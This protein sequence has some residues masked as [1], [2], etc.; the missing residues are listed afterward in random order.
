MGAMSVLVTHVRGR[1]GELET[2]ARRRRE[3]LSSAL[4]PVLRAR[5]AELLREDERTIDR[6]R[7]FIAAAGGAR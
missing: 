1:L 6:A 3:V 4:P 5:V 7:R 2:R